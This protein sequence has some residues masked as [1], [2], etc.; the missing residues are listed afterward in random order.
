MSLD[1]KATSGLSPN[2]TSWANPINKPPYYGVAMTSHLT[3]TSGGPKVDT[4]SR[5]FSRKGV[6]IP[7]LYAVGELTGLFY[8]GYPS[9][10]SCLRSM[11][12]GREAGMAIAKKLVTVCRPTTATNGG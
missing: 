12:F 1:C 4:G 2:E 11:A 8:H 10:T 3:L 9:V 5:V 6:P 7:G